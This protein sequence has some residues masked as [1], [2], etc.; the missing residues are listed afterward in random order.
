MKKFFLRKS[1]LLPVAASFVLLCAGFNN[2]AKKKIIA[3][4]LNKNLYQ[5]GDIV[6]RE[7]KGLIS[8]AFSKM[9]LKEKKY[10]HAGFIVTEGNEWL[11]YHFIDKGKKGITVE[12][13]EDFVSDEECSSFAVYHPAYS[14]DQQMTIASLI[15]NPVDRNKEFDS[16]FDLKTDDK[17]YCTEWIYKLLRQTGFDIPVSAV[18]NTEYVAPDNLYINNFTRRVTNESYQS[19]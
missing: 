9:S 16:D 2:K 3:P 14:Q 11:V 7:G 19:Q 10:S 13:L 8:S 18:N 12:K 17:F 1:L 6:L 15:K 5:T 4:A